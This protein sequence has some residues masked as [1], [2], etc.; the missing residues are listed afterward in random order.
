MSRLTTHA[1]FTLHADGSLHA[2]LYSPN[3]IHSYENHIADIFRCHW[4]SSVI[5]ISYDA[6]LSVILPTNEEL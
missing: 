2:A 1:Y 5:E 4:I 3:G 6:M